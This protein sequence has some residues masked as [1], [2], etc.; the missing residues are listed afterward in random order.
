MW[1]L[2]IFSCAHF[3]R[4]LR[5]IFFHLQNRALHCSFP[6]AFSPCLN[7][8]PWYQMKLPMLSTP[9]RLSMSLSHKAKYTKS[10]SSKCKEALSSRKRLE[11]NFQVELLGYGSISA[12]KR[13]E[14]NPNFEMAWLHTMRDSFYKLSAITTFG[15]RDIS[16]WRSALLESSCY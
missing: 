9:Q 7:V 12:S 6:T 8:R 14:P 15:F 5:E 2:L 1:R 3:K 11:K 10:F 16:R 4:R 13:K